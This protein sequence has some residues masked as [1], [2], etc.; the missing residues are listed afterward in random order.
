MAAPSAVRHVWFHFGSAL[1]AVLVLCAASFAAAGSL[2]R[3]AAVA[4]VLPVGAALLF[5]LGFSLKVVR[6]M[7]SPIPFRI[8]LTTGQH[9]GAVPADH[10]RFRT[11]HTGWQ[12]IA[13]TLIDGA[14]FRPLL[15]STPSVQHHGRGLFAYSGRL[16]WVVAGAFHLSLGVVL[17]RH[18]RLFLTPVPRFVVW[19][20]GAD[21]VS[22]LFIPKLNAT[23]FLILVALFWLLARRLVLVRLR[24]ISL[25]ADYFPLLLLLGIAVTG[26]LMRHVTRTDVSEVKAMAESVAGLSFAIQTPVDSLLVVH[27]FLVCAL[28]A[29]F[30]VSKLMHMPGVFMSPTLTLAANSR[31]KR[32]INVNN[33]IV[34]TLHYSDYEATFRDRMI[35]AG[36]PV[37]KE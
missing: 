25:A 20:Q 35:E 14:L 2:G 8:A 10:D 27:V 36:L 31:A 9:R 13:R 34:P 28:L 37:E 24:Y 30:P 15:R 23:S 17:L 18:L 4:L 19:L 1:L 6:W 29:Y 33:P 3:F 32:H 22:D 5:V 26:V 16:L 21:S 11:P 12:T 7:R